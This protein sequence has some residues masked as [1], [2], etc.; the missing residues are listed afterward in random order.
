GVGMVFLP[1]NASDRYECERL[2]E[3]IVGQEKQTF[4]GWRTVPTHNASLGKTALAGEPCIRQLFVRRNPDI[5]T[6]A[7]FE[8]R[9]YIIRKR[10]ERAVR[11][12]G[13]AQR[14]MFYVPSL[15]HKTII[16]KGM[17]KAD[18]L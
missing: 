16:Y 2:V 8:R 17:L 4:L 3:E 6:E 15:S 9:L 14:G 7:A 18:Q 11:E 5:P 1:T 12:S 10:V 13:L